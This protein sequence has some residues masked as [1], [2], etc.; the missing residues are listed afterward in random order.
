MLTAALQ[1]D[2]NAMGPPHRYAWQT[3][4]ETLMK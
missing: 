3:D 1:F 4:R 2:S